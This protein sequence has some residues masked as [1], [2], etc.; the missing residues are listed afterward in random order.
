MSTCPASEQRKEGKKGA[1][2]PARDDPCHPKEIPPGS[3][4]GVGAGSG[5]TGPSLVGKIM[6]VPPKAIKAKDQE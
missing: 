5:K 2:L 3:G 4:V 1:N 6:I